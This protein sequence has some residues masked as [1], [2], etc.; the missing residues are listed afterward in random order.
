MKVKYYLKITSNFSIGERIRSI[1]VSKVKSIIIC[2]V[3]GL[4]NDLIDWLKIV[5]IKYTVGGSMT[6]PRIIGM[7]VGTKPADLKG[8]T[9][10]SLV[11]GWIFASTIYLI[12]HNSLGLYLGH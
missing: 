3:D 1:P 5:W 6:N 10:S 12:S 7:L 4:G 2:L 8:K 11:Y 9:M